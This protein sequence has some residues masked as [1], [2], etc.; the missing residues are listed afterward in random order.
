MNFPLN[1]KCQIKITRDAL[2]ESQN[3]AG[4]DKVENIDRNFRLT[5]M[6]IRLTNQFKRDIKKLKSSRKGKHCRRYP[7]NAR[8]S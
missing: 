8:F 4:L 2:R 6:Q 3:V 5:I 7:E 1:L